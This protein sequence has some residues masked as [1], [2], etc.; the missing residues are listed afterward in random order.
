MLP[1]IGIIRYGKNEPLRLINDVKDRPRNASLS[2]CLS[3]A[4]FSHLRAT[5][6]RASLELASELCPKNVQ[7]TGNYL[8]RERARTRRLRAA[9]YILALFSRRGTA[10]GISHSL[11]RAGLSAASLHVSSRFCPIMNRLR[12]TER[13]REKERASEILRRNIRARHATRLSR[14]FQPRVTCRSRKRNKS[15][16]RVGSTFI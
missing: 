8:P 11:S 2:V 7:I 6:A 15:C 14:F 1:D 10:A 16:L 9:G 5:T 4:F 12:S 3:V 13:E